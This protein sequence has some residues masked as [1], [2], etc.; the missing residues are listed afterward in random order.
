MGISRGNIT[1][2]IIKK[3][4]VFNMDAANRASTIP[5]STTSIA[6]N[7][8]NTA[9]SGAFNSDA[10]YD[11]STISPSF[12]FDGVDDYILTN[13]AS[14]LFTNKFTMSFWWNITDTS[15]SNTGRYICASRNYYTV[16]E[17]GNF[18]YRVDPPNSIIFQSYDGRSSGQFVQS[19]GL[20][21][22]S[23]TWM[24]TVL[25]SD[26]TTAGKHYINGSIH[27]VGSRN[28]LSRNLSDISNGI[29]FGDVIN[30]A[31]TDDDFKIGPIHFY[32]RALSASEVLFNY[33]GLKSRLGL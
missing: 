18:S 25:T 33:N 21:L 2:N 9:I 22:Q 19:T 6:F 12:A 16:G 5:S 13:D 23:N 10:Q 4:L 26:G 1:T 29:L 31:T 20:S 27:E 28:T 7:T 3:G 14:S 11:S 24:N 30:F 32:N 17:D 8:V 15:T